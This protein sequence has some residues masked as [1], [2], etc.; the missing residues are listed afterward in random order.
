MGALS[1]RARSSVGPEE[2]R[3]P[4]TRP[5]QL[6]LAPLRGH[7]V[8]AAP[9]R[10]RTGAVTVLLGPADLRRQVLADLDEATTR[11]AAGHAAARV[12]RLAP[13]ADEPAESR[14]RTLQELANDGC[15]LLLADGPTAGLTGADRRCVLVALRRL[16]RTGT[17]VLTDDVD[18][19]AALAVADAGLR[20]AADGALTSDDLTG[21]LAQRAE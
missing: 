15:A 20:V 21:P 6:L 11:C 19:V 12:H 1:R 3:A 17:A 7:L 8:N 5:Q 16:S 9:L 10:L 2:D 4:R 13:G 18:P 14:V